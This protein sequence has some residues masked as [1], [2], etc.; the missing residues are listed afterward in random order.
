MIKRL[1]LSGFLLF[2][3]CFLAYADASAQDTAKK[4][5]PVIKAPDLRTH[6]IKAPENTV[7]IPSTPPKAKPH[8]HKVS[9]TPTNPA[10]NPATNTAVNPATLVNKDSANQSVLT[11]SNQPIIKTLHGQYLFLLSKIYHYQQPFAGALWK[12]VND[13]LRNYKGQIKILQAKLT[14]QSKLTDSVKTGAEAKIEELS[15]PSEKENSISL[16]GIMMSKASYNLLMFGLVFGLAIA[17]AVVILTTA[18]YKYEAKHRTELYDDIDEEF[19]AYKV[20]ANEKEKK[21]ARELQTE[22]NKLDELLGRG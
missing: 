13:T 22:R 17:L 7:L 6:E 14:A 12:S 4:A 8:Y 16:F 20:K 2:I 3:L 18:K 11:D 10:A 5:E 19:R 21:L 15:R 9:P 1:L